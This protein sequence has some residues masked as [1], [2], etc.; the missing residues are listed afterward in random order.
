MCNAKGLK[1][2][3]ILVLKKLDIW[4]YNLVLEQE[5]YTPSVSLSFL[6]NAGESSTSLHASQGSDQKANT[7]CIDSHIY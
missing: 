5:N 4:G 2:I 6:W 7:K 3:F 1:D